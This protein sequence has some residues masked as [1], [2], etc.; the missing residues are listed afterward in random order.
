MET[1]LKR[2]QLSRPV[3]VKAVRWKGYGLMVYVGKDLR[4]RYLLSLEWNRLVFSCSVFVPVADILNILC[5]VNLFFSVLDELYVLNH[6]L[7]SL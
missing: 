7:C 5:D 6:A 4:R 3:S 1:K 2:K